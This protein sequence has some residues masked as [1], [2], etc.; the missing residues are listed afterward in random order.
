MA[1]NRLRGP[2]QGRELELMLSGEKPGAMLHREQWA[3]FAPHIKAGRFIARRFEIDG[4]ED[5]MAVTQRGDL[6]RLNE[7]VK[8]FSGE[9]RDHVKIGLLLGYS[10]EAIRFFVNEAGRYSR[11]HSRHRK[12][13]AQTQ[14]RDAA[15]VAVDGTRA[16]V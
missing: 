11:G 9:G 10:K 5:Y 15:R 2:H 6:W 4:H 13:G 1:P 3:A 7:I 14:N 8:Q 12:S 16:T